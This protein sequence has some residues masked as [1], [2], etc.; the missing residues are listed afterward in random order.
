MPVERT[1]I[2][3]S[4][5]KQS[6][7]INAII[8]ILFLQFYEFKRGKRGKNCGEKSNKTRINLQF[9]S[10]STPTSYARGGLRVPMRHDQ[11]ESEP[12]RELLIADNLLWCGKEL[13]KNFNFENAFRAIYF[14]YLARRPWDRP[15]LNRSETFS[16]GWQLGRLL[17]ASCV[18]RPAAAIWGMRKL[19]T[20]NRRQLIRLKN[21][22]WNVHSINYVR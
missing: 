10:T 13:S 8:Y 19:L 21:G 5:R 17:A 16:C 20:F 11:K 9:I 22:C 18:N 15:L 4:W 12:A 2:S 7:E 1:H 14:S 6:Q 3:P